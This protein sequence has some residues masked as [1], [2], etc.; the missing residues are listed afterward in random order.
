MTSPARVIFSAIVF[1]LAFVSIARA[2]VGGAPE[3]PQTSTQP[4][5]MLVGSHGNFCTGTAIAPDL[6]L[7]AAHCIA[8]GTDY[9]LVELSADLKPVL[10]DTTAVARH[11]QFNLKLM[12]AHRATADVALLKLAAPLSVTPAALLALRPRVA[13]GERF[14]VHG[15]GAS[16]RGD[17]NSA[18]RLREV[19]LIAT[20]QP[21]NLQ[22]RLVDPATGGARPGLGACTGDSGA[23]AYQET[24]AGLAI[25]GVVSWSTGPNGADGCGG[26]TGVTPLELYRGWIEEQAKRMGSAVGP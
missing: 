9:K 7:T 1:I 25:I 20:G 2:M 5:V 6:V 12:L 3:I 14:V 15:Y 4:E 13:V 18:G 23:P 22:L 11:P 24:T 16:I 21:G 26:L 10:K 19:T 8:A 17:G